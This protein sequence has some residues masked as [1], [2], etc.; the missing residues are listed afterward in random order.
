MDPRIGGDF[1]SSNQTLDGNYSR[2]NIYLDQAYFDWK[3]ASWG[4]LMGGKMRIPFVRTG[5]EQFYDGDIN[6][7]GVALQFNR[8]MWFGSV[9]GTW[10]DEVS[11]AESSVT[12]DTFLNGVQVGARV[13]IG[14]SSLMLMAHY[15]DL[16]AGQGKRIFWNCAA[17]SNACSNGNTTTGAP[18]AGVLTYDFDVIQ[19]AT[20]WNTTIA[21]QPFQAWGQYAQ[22]LDPSDMNTAWSAGVFYGAA[23]NYRTWEV[24]A[25]YQLVEKDSLFGHLIDSDFGAGATDMR[26]YML[27]AGYAPLR[28]WVF[29]ATYFINERNIDVGTKSDYDRL[30]L[31][32]NLRF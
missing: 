4:N 1:R 30:Q 20:Q 12:S 24:G 10:V 17:L 26:G 11:G 23:A 27:K 18:G 16:V 25:M 13:P 15:Y 5:Q 7:E 21:G 8:G 2:K 22:N 29:N 3:F 6:P 9:Y 14:S 31:D 19:L 28:N 32:M